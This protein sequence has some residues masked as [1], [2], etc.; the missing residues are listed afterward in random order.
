MEAASASGPVTA[1]RYDPTIACRPSSFHCTA[2]PTAT[3]GCAIESWM[4]YTSLK[5]AGSSAAASGTS[6]ATR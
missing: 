4:S 1:D 3:D 5:P 2:C 6:E